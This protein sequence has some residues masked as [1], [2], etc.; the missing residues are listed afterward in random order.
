MSRALV[1]SAVVLLAIARPASAEWHLS[2]MV[3][4]TFSGST[5]IVDLE[6][7]SGKV[8]GHFGGAVSL[9]GGGL[10]GAEAV[11]M[12]TPR[13]FQTHGTTNLVASSRTMAL[14]G[15]MMVTAPRR[16]TEY[17]LRPFV[18]A[19]FGVL[20]ASATERY[21][22]LP[23]GEIFPI[24]ENISSFNVGGGAIGF[25]TARTGLRLDV[26]Y[27]SNLH[28][29]NTGGPS[30]GRVQLRYMTVSIGLVFRR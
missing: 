27:F 21:S 17:S 2:P 19:G 13:F 30:I 18:S 5:T 9:L 23:G 29:S 20:H 6:H 25:L 16:L 28:H 12:V 3:G 7:A 26:R 24:S 8:H 1:L 4:L 14:M 11:V 22:L 10:F 15:N